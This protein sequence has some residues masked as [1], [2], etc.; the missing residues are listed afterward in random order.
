MTFQQF[1]E[2]VQRKFLKLR[3]QPIRVF[4][5]H[6]VSDVFE[7][8]KCFNC[9]WTN[10]DQFKRVI[11]SLQKH[12]VFISLEEAYRH[13]CNDKI[14]RQNY[15][16]LT[17]D[18]GYYSLLNI[19]P[20]LELNRIPI[21]LFLNSHYLDGKHYIADLYCQAKKVKPAIDEE[22]FVKNLY[23][24]K[25]DLL[26]MNFDW[27]SLG[28]HG[29]EHVPV[30]GMSEEEFEAQLNDSLACIKCMKGYVPFYAYTFGWHTKSTDE[31][32]RKSGI[33]PVLIDGGCNINDPSVIHRECIDK[34]EV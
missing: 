13:I 29:H 16:V 14:R 34:W 31:K 10:I 6:Q 24:T 17:S 22:T 12:Y 30:V 28:L 5:F 4:C 8:E 33:V 21:T 1:W 11:L 3:L 2:K 19:L 26:Q 25:E 15:A 20:W 23:L 18:D 27:V 9:D 7:P 32:L